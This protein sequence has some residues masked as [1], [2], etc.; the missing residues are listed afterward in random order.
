MTKKVRIC[1]DVHGL[2]TRSRQDGF[3]LAKEAKG[4]TYLQIIH[5]SEYN[6]QLGDMGWGEDNEIF[7]NGTVPL[8]KFKFCGGNHDDYD[9]PLPH[10][11]GDYG[12][13]ELNGVEFGFV[14]GE[15]SVDK[16]YRVHQ[17]THKSWWEQEELTASQST[18]CYEYF[19]GLSTQP[20]LVLSHGCPHFLLPQVVTNKWK[21]EPSWTSRLLSAVYGV[22]RPRLWICGHHH[23]NLV[24]QHEET[25]F[26]VLNEL[27]YVDL[28]I[29]DGKYVLTGDVELRVK[30]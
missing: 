16:A 30:K 9:N 24:L 7:H 22:V 19:E 21:L 12:V 18:A 5:G 15:Y 26:V 29:V 11:L 20:S 2:V 6:I 28:A 25:M 13:S 27:C 4:R 10:S 3:T 23:R 1:A 8:D 17:G 14:R